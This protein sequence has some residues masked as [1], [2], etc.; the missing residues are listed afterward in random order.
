M[1]KKTKFLNWS[2]YGHFGGCFCDWAQ[3]HDHWRSGSRFLRIKGNKL[4]FLR[5]GG[6]HVYQERA[7]DLN[8]FQQQFFANKDCCQMKNDPRSCDRN[9][10]NCVKK[11]EKNSGLQRG[12]NPW[13][14][15]YRCDALPTELW[16]HWRWEQVICYSNGARYFPDDGLDKS[17]N[18]L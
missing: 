8:L 3:C 11:P 13:P 1:K 4:W 6:V 15:E 9:L 12:L 7:W 18:F 16:S 5:I 2:F 14:R 17:L 10:Y